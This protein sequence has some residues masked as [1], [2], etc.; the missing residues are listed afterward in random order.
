MREEKVP[1]QPELRKLFLTCDLKA[2]ASASLVAHAGL[3][4]E[5]LGDYLGEDGL[6]VR[7]IPDLSIKGGVDR[8]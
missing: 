1:T 4:L 2:R 8:V 7:D 5:V 3:R 6:Q